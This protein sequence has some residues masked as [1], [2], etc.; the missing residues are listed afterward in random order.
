MNTLVIDNID[1]FVYNLVQYSGILGTEPVVMQNTARIEDIRE[2]IKEEGITHIIISPGPKAPKDAGVSNQVIKE[3]GPDIPVLGVC[4][5]HQC[6]GQVYGAQIIRAKNIMHGKTSTI[7]HNNKGLYIGLPNPLT[8]GRYHSLVIDRESIPECLEVT[9]E[10]LEDNEVMGVKH[11]D[12]SV[13][14]VQFHP[15]SVLTPDGMKILYN[16][17][18]L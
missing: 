4:L 8:A 7:K 15:E 10:S 12:H 16:F 2:L 1:S 6:I 17:F 3:F 5:G 14:G 9:A 11:R 18:R 13:Y